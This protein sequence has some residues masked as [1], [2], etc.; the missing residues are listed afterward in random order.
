MPLTLFD[1][2]VRPALAQALT[3][4]MPVECG[5]CGAADVNLCERCVDELR[6]H[7]SRRALAGVDGDVPLWSGL[8]FEGV[9]ARVIRAVK[10][11]GR[12]SLISSLTPALN[13][14]VAKVSPPADTVV[15]PLPTSRA[16]YRR[17]GYRVPDR[18]AARTTLPVAR[19]LRT[20]RR[21]ADQRG[22]TIMQRRENVSLSM[23]SMDAAGRRVIVLDDVVTTGATLQEAIRA[24]RSA[25][26]IVLGAVTVAATPRQASS[27]YQTSAKSERRI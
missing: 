25:G 1:D 13:A 27:E 2:L 20:A 11:D 18:L 10:E 6:P 8:R 17:R 22:L 14:A 9:A 7:P 15:V 16:A 5:G 21:T 24:L 23:R 3:L 12:T 4:V 19:L 26:A